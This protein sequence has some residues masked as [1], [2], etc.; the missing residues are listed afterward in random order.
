[1]KFNLKQKLVLFMIL[2]VA[3]PFSIYGVITY[4]REA[5]NTR[6]H[7]KRQNQLLVNELSTSVEQIIMEKKNLV[8]VLAQT[9]EVKEM[10]AEEQNELL[11]K[12]K[13]EDDIFE[14]LFVQD[15]DGKVIADSEEGGVVV[16]EDLGFR[17]YFE[18]AIEGEEYISESYISVATDRPCITISLPIM[19]DNG[20]VKGVLAADIDL[21]ILQEMVTNID[22]IEGYAYITDQTGA[23]IAHPDFEERVL[24]QSNAQEIPAVSRALEGES[25]VDRYYNDQEVEM[26]GAYAPVNGLDWVVVVQ[27]YTEQ[28]F[29]DIN[30]ILIIN[31]VIL[32]IAIGVAVGVAFLIANGIAKP[33]RELDAKMKEVG[34]GN[35]KTK[36][37][38]DRSDELG[39]LGAQFNQMVSEEASII[40]KVLET[41][42]SLTLSSKELSAIADET[43]DN[44]E[45][46]ASNIQEMSAGIEQ[47]AASTQQINSFAEQ[48]ATNADQG[49]LKID[50][51]IAEMKTIKREVQNAVESIDQLDQKSDEIGEII[52]LITNIAEQTNLL[53]LNAAIEAAR[54]GEHGQGF[55]VVAEEIRQLAEETTQATDKIAQLITETQQE[56]KVA[57]SAVE[58]GADEVRQGEEIIN[59]AGLIFKEIVAG[60]NDTSEQIQEASAVIQQLA[61]GSDQVLQA[62]E[63][64]TAVTQDVTSSADKLS[65][66]AAELERVTNRFEV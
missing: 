10:N 45:K 25:G 56:S 32:L 51:A 2:L 48:T 3:I 50:E 57:I 29:S 39:D 9:K 11:R 42:N 18:A 52:D 33:V 12:V 43:N 46:T 22:N 26:L 8:K 65:E 7:V 24:E 19:G 58:K 20:K 13:E 27:N 5:N 6:T 60:I 40:Q 1:M 54:A 31:L 35:L 34:Q 66:L 38:I 53:A 14:L 17:P 21:H 61:S 44:I 63:E 59:K 41:T 64:V 28:A 23:V 55:A 4:N 15:Q 30:Q 16:G 47:V 49:Q 36:V 62:T 37:E